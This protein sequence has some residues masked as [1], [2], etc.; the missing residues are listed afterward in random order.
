MRVLVC[1]DRNWSNPVS[2]W[3]T[4]DSAHAEHPITCIIEGEAAGADVLGRGWGLQKGIQVLPFPAQWDKY[5]K[6][7]GPIR[8]RQMIDEGKPDIVFAFHPDI[9]ASKGTRDMVNA[10]K[11]AGIPVRIFEK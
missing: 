8:N 11:H 6:S 1:G 7:A 9:R 3:H 2:L 10:A 5:G 4:L